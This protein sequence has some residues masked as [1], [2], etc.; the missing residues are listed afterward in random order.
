MADTRR[1]ICTKSW[2]RNKAGDVIERWLYN[3]YPAEIRQENFK[4]LEE[5]VATP[6]VD[7]DPEE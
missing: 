3:K 5:S 1:Y 2:A 6:V 7:S 4:L